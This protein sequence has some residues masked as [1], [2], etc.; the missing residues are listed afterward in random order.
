MTATPASARPALETQARLAGEP[1]SGRFHAEGASFRC[2]CIARPGGHGRPGPGL[3][4]GGAC[5]VGGAHPCGQPPLRPGSLPRARHRQA[6]S[7]R[8]R[9]VPGPG[10]RRCAPRH[11]SV[12]FQLVGLRRRERDLRLG[13]LHLDR[14]D[15]EL[16]QRHVAGQPGERPARR[17]RAR[18]RWVRSG[19]ACSVD[20]ARRRPSG[21]VSTA[22]TRPA[23]SSSGP[24]R[25][26]TAAPPPT[27][28]GTR[29]TP[30][31]RRTS[32]TRSARATP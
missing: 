11:R 21:S 29:C 25:T 5:C 16:Q 19:P 12:V 13:V 7:P 26:A 2:P 20:P 31:P 22:T 32:A 8:P 1:E 23:S 18:G 4:R 14:A 28:P 27:T 9:L 3:R 17:T 24:T 30:T 15:R 10:R 6:P